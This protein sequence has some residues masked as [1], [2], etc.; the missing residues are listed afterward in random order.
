MRR[1]FLLVM[2]LNVVF[3]AWQVSGPP[4]IDD[5]YVADL[6]PDGGQMQGLR[7]IYLLSEIGRKRSPTR[8]VAPATPAEDT[9]TPEASV[10]QVNEVCYRLGPF[11]SPKRTATAAAR[12][13]AEG[14]NSDT[15]IEEEPVAT[16][17]L[18]SLPPF[19]TFD[20]A[21]KQL[22]DLQQS[23]VEDLG[24][25]SES[26]NYIVS[27]G[28]YRLPESAR[29]RMEEITALGYK[30]RTTERIKT[31]QTYWLDYRLAEDQPQLVDKWQVLRESFEKISQHS[32]DCPAPL[33]ASAP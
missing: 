16:M 10:A 28:F 26:P 22:A 9:T 31:K 11:D 32:R 24:I 5:P 6:K 13:D 20:A 23:G 2:L 4:R 8:S 12:L 1:L 3:F 18:V 17:Y 7:T 30:P 29:S 14:I 27:L 25:V 21:K 19:E 15:H 33:S